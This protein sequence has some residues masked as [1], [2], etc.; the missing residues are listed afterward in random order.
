MLILIIH[1]TSLMVLSLV[2]TGHVQVC[3]TRLSLIM[4]S[5][6]YDL[7]TQNQLQYIFT[8]FDY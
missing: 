5:L 4:Q 7:M 8:V 2:R 1:V 6:V 3:A